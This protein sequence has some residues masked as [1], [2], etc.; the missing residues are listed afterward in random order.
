MDGY[1][2]IVGMGVPLSDSKGDFIA[3]WIQSIVR[4][5]LPEN[6]HG[7]LFRKR[8]GQGSQPSLSV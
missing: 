2:G 5:S 6:L 3:L 4:F 8:Q 1:M 7:F